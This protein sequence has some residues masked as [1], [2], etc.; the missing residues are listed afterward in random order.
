[1]SYAY[2]QLPE[3]M[4]PLDDAKTT[5]MLPSAAEWRTS[6]PVN[7]VA[8]DVVVKGKFASEAFNQSKESR[9]KKGKR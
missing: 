1:M 5:E 6:V 8:R 3:D 2:T 4:A 7:Q 9:D